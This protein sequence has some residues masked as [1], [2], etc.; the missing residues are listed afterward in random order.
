MFQY[1]LEYPTALLSGPVPASWG[2]LLAILP[3][4]SAPLG[5]LFFSKIK[6]S[7]GIKD[8]STI[9]PGHGGMLDRID[10]HIFATTIT[11]LVL[12]MMM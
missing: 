4:I 2:I 5:D 1:G 10:S 6:R 9:L 12:A 8:F 11:I 3:A 7:A